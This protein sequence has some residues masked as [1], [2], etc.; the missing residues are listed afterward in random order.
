MF[1]CLS[2]LNL[3]FSFI[4]FLAFFFWFE[5]IFPL[6]IVIYTFDHR[7]QFT[8]AA[9]KK[10]VEIYSHGDNWMLKLFLSIAIISIWP[11]DKVL[12][13]ERV[14]KALFTSIILTIDR[15]VQFLLST[16]VLC[17]HR[18]I[19]V[20]SKQSADPLKDSSIKSAGNSWLE[21]SHMEKEK[22][23]SKQR[24]P[25]LKRNG[26]RAMRIHVFAFPLL[27]AFMRFHFY[28]TWF[29]CDARG[30]SAQC[31]SPLFL[32]TIFTN[33]K[34]ALDNNKK[35]HNNATLFHS[36]VCDWMP[37][38]FESLI[39]FATTILIRCRALSVY[40]LNSAKIQSS[41]Q[42]MQF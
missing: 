42:V 30:D 2:F 34:E 24:P 19:M 39:G 4:H 21:S 41:S 25:K 31:H 35:V 23:L 5:L 40:R 3:P 1:S 13:R 37:F 33:C 18:S 7:I 16:C 28:F 9:H 14:N 6:N 29:N 22:T 26:I 32:C 8:M 38:F 36:A 12:K 10:K 20:L 17:T 15:V 11:L 27:L